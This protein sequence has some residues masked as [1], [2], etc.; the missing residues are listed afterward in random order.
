[1]GNMPGMQHGGM[2]HGQMKMGPESNPM[3]MQ[4][5]EAEKKA[6][7]EKMKKTSEE[8]KE[9][10]EALKEKTEQTTPGTTN[11]TCPMHPEVQSAKPGKCP[12][13]GMKLVPK[14]ADAHEAH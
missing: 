10:S 14:K 2:E 3:P 1:M 4:N 13:C 11:Y 6:L 7:T 9:T 5:V 12:K 8:M